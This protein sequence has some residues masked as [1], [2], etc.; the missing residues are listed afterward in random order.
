MMQC[1]S[2]NTNLQTRLYQ[3]C[4]QSR[5]RRHVAYMQSNQRYIIKRNALDSDDLIDEKPLTYHENYDPN[6]LPPVSLFNV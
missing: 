2:A 5:T 6:Y 1:E 3:E 4:P